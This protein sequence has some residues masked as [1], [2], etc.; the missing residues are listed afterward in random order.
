MPGRI[1]S[2]ENAQL[3]RVSTIAANFNNDDPFSF[4]IDRPVNLPIF[5]SNVS[6]S[7]IDGVPRVRWEAARTS[8]LAR[9]QVR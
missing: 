6:D 3:G 1:R 4:A 9:T 2:Q 5:L 7:Y 8:R